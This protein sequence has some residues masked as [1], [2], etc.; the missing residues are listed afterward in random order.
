LHFNL[1]QL[2]ASWCSFTLED[3][4]KG[5]IPPAYPLQEVVEYPPQQPG[6]HQPIL[7]VSAARKK[8]SSMPSL[9]PSVLVA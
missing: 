2:T 6:Y 7:A 4:Q 5:Y 8:L 1:N 3:L 9:L